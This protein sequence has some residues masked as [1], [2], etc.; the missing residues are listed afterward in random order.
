MT[1]LSD[2]IQRARLPWGYVPPHAGKSIMDIDGL[3]V[4]DA[5]VKTS[6]GG[7]PFT[8]PLTRAY[9]VL[10]ANALPA[11]VE[12]LRSHAAD[13]RSVKQNHTP[14]S[15]TWFKR[16]ALLLEAALAELERKAEEMGHD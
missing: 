12:V 3:R 6:G 14:R 16:R 7:Y 5:N 2:L 11:L 1:A 13:L 8:D 10:A 15:Q 4:T 9:A